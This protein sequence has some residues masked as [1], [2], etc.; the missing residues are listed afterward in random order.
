MLTIIE[1]YFCF[2]PAYI[3]GMSCQLLRP[4]FA[5]LQHILM[6]LV[7]AYVWHSYS[8]QKTVNVANE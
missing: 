1:T 7:D 4:I 6:V 5:V 2:S 3:N 8:T